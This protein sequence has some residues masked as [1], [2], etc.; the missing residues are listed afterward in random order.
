M[1]YSGASLAYNL[2]SI[3]GASIPTLVAMELNKN[4]GLMGVGLYMAANGAITMLALYLSRETRDM[5]MN[6][7]VANTP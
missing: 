1:R 5:D 3:V 4:Y 6:E 7:T 2:S